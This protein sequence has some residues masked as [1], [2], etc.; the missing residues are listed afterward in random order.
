VE[1]RLALFIKRRFLCQDLAHFVA[2][3][4]AFGLEK[5]HMLCNTHFLQVEVNMFRLTQIQLFEVRHVV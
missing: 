4:L 2:E 5:T 3:M 1:N